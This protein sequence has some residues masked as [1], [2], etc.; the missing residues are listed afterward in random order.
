MIL[1]PNNL[2]LRWILQLVELQN[3]MKT[4]KRTNFLVVSTPLKLKFTFSD[5]IYIIRPKNPRIKN[6][7]KKKTYKTLNGMKID[8]KNKSSSSF[9]PILIQIEIFR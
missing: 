8:K 4:A 5:L 6:N 7:L 1:I 2:L 3:T 9:Y